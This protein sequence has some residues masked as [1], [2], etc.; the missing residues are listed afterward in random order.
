MKCFLSGCWATFCFKSRINCLC[1][2]RSSGDLSGDRNTDLYA[3]T[4]LNLLAFIKIW[5]TGPL[6]VSVTLT[7]LV[8]LAD[9][10]PTRKAKKLGFSPTETNT[11]LTLFDKVS[12][13]SSSSPKSIRFLLLSSSSTTACTTFFKVSGEKIAGGEYR[14][15][16]D[17][18]D[19]FQIF[20]RFFFDFFSFFT[21]PG[22]CQRLDMCFNMSVTLHVSWI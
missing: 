16:H 18:F 15:W 7:G 20:F 21:A 14:H 19:F 17:F 13:N 3:S 5:F 4:V 8:L 22:A 12:F 10:L 1:W 9:L 2:V 6:P 11:S